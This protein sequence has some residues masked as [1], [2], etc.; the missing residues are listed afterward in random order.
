M[1]KNPSKAGRHGHRPK[2]SAQK[3][4]KNQNSHTAGTTIHFC[5]SPLT[6]LGGGLRAWLVFVLVRG[7]LLGVLTTW[8]CLCW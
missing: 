4:L 6:I 5:L 3:N 2:I 7:L 1:A 8:L